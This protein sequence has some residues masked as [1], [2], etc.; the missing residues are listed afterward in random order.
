M[1][2]SHSPN[3][4]LISVT[5][6]TFH[7]LSGWLKEYARQNILCIFVTLDTFQLLSGWLKEVAPENI[8]L[9]FVTLDTFQELSVVIPLPKPIFSSF[10]LKMKSKCSAKHV[11]T[12]A[13]RNVPSIHF[14]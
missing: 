5:L 1:K 12:Y 6:D 11:Y 9:I 4:K 10:F 14:V 2:E 3:I 8:H 13:L 7:L